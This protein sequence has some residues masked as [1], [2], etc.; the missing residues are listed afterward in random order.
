MLG[1]GKTGAG[2]IRRIVIFTCD[3]HYRQTNATWAH[4]LVLSLAIWWANSSKATSRNMSQIA[5]VLAVTTAFISFW[6]LILRQRRGTYMRDKN[7]Y[8]GT[9]AKSTGGAYMWGGGGVD[10]IAVFYGTFT[11]VFI[12][13]AT[14]YSD[15]LKGGEEWISLTGFSSTQNFGLRSHQKQSQRLK[16]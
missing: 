9:W 16:S 2:L 1:L 11:D 8:A 4:D 5:S 13:E 12:I 6:N 3:D 14:V 15:Y 10:V 7:T